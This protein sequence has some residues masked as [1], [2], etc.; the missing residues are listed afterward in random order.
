MRHNLPV[1]P[2]KRSSKHL[3]GLVSPAD[4]L[5]QIVCRLICLFFLIIFIL[6][7]GYVLLS[8]VH[9]RGSWGLDGYLLL[10][11]NDLVLTGLKNSVLLALLG[12][13]YSL[14][15]EIPA[16]FVLSKKQYGWL[17]N[18][19]F[20]LGQFGVALLPLYLLLKQMG[21]LNSL[22]G[23][24]LPTGLSVYYTQMLRARM[25]NLPAELEDA[26]AMDGCGPLRYL[27]GICLPLI[28]PTVGV[29]AFFHICG[30]WSNTLLARTFLTDERK[31]P[32][33]LVLDRVLIRNQGADVFGAVVTAESLAALQMAE[34]GLCVISA[35][36][37]ILAFLFIKK[38]VRAMETDGGVVM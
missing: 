17:T 15:L 9:S 6:P 2:D 31:F 12:T 18:L 4:K 11:Q 24:I 35:L 16:A 26:A 1:P 38:H 3:K 22:W 14:A 10:L 7:I 21:L 36:P 29:F 8:S 25:I 13:A 34:F 37:P 23:L 32:L 28:G 5:T 27:F 33:T 20:A 19:F 30:Y